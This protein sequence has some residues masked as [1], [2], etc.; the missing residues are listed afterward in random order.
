MENSDIPDDSIDYSSSLDEETTGRLN[1]DPWVP[2]EGDLEPFMQITLN[3]RSFITGIAIQGV[4]EEKYIS[5]IRIDYQRLGDDEWSTLTNPGTN[6]PQVKIRTILISSLRCSTFF[7][8]N[9]KYS[10]SQNK[11]YPIK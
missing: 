4:D 6:I 2:Q 11:L 3:K 7:F 9:L 8:E 10:T 1:G 5:K